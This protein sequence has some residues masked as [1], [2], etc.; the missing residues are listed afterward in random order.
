[1]RTLY[2]LP[3]LDGDDEL[4]PRNLTKEELAKVDHTVMKWIC[5]AKG[6]KRFTRVKD[7]GLFPTVYFRT[8]EWVNVHVHVLYCSRHWKLHHAALIAGLPDPITLKDDSE[9]FEELRAMK[10]DWRQPE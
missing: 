10:P 2:P 4:D 8:G 6:C 3:D 9:R 5:C 1:M 7:Y